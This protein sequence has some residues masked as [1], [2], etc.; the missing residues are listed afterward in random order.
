[1]RGVRLLAVPLAE[2][3]RDGLK[4]ALKKAGLPS[5]DVCAPGRRFWRF[6]QD[7]VPV[8]FG[9]LELHDGAALLRS[10]VTLPPVRGRGLGRAI[11]RMLEIEAR[12]LNCR[13]IY[14]LAENA[15]E[16]FARQGYR[17]CK[18]GEIPAAI[19]ASERFSLRPAS[20]TVMVKQ[21]G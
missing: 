17:P 21:L 1:M 14:L 12:A 6:E 9:G 4:A 3:E 5:E 11:T 15:S 19:G 8:G 10:L 7:D 13:T 16:F 2:W 20:A 18:R